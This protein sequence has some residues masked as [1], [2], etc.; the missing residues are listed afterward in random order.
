MT[1]TEYT[2]T[3][4]NKAELLDR[5]RS[6]RVALERALADLDEARMNAPVENGWTIKDIVAHITA[7]EQILRQFHLGDTPF[8]QASGLSNVAYGKDSVEVINEQLYRRDKDKPLSEVLAAFHASYERVL[9]TV[10]AIGEARL[11]G[12]YVPRGRE[13]S[14]GGQL[15]DWIAGDTYEHY[16]E[17]R[18]TIEGLSRQG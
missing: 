1:D 5:I 6:E 2:S 15:V 16:L 11:F 18:L 13:T 7:W 17:H 8:N 4:T 9:A 12:H 10:E 14:D 3:P